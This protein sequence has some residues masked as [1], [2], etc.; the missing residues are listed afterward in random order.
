MKTVD[1]KYRG[2]PWAFTWPD[3][4]GDKDAIDHAGDVSD[5]L[6]ENNLK[7]NRDYVSF[8]IDEAPRGS[9]FGNWTYC[10]AFKDRNKALMYKVAWA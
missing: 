8:E 2:F 5:W 4:P 1:S 9:R 7:H 6:H 3:R 10:I